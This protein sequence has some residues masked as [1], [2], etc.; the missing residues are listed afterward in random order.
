MKKLVA[1]LCAMMMFWGDV[2]SVI[3]PAI[4]TGVEE[5][6]G[7]LNPDLFPSKQE[8]DD[9]ISITSL[10]ET[11]S[12]T[13]AK[14]NGEGDGESMP[15]VNAGGLDEGSENST[16]S[17][18]PDEFGEN[19]AAPGGENDEITADDGIDEAVDELE[20]PSEAETESDTEWNGEQQ[21]KTE[22][23]EEPGSVF[24]EKPH[25]I[26]TEEDMTEGQD[27]LP[28]EETNASEQ[29]VEEEG[30]ETAEE[31]AE[32]I[33]AEGIYNPFDMASLFAMNDLQ[34]FALTEV[35][36]EVK[37]T[38][39][40]VDI[41][42][43]KISFSNAVGATLPSEGPYYY[44]LACAY[45]Q[46]AGSFGQVNVYAGKRITSFGSIT[47]ELTDF[48]AVNTGTTGDIYKVQV[49]VY[50]SDVIESNIWRENVIQSIFNGVDNRFRIAKQISGY[51]LKNNGYGTIS[52]KILNWKFTLSEPV[53]EPELGS[54]EIQKI[55]K[56]N[57]NETTSGIMDGTY[58]FNIRSAEVASEEEGIRVEITINNGNVT[59]VSGNAI[60][61]EAGARIDQLPIGNYTVTETT[62][63]LSSKYIENPDGYSHMATVQKDALA[64]VPFVSN[65]NEGSLEIG[66]VT[67]GK[68]DNENDAF[69]FTVE[70]RKKDKNPASGYTLYTSAGDAITFS[71]GAHDFIISPGRAVEIIHIPAGF[72]YTVTQKTIPEN[73]SLEQSEGATVSGTIFTG[74]VSAKFNYQ[75][76][77]P[78]TTTEA[79]AI[80]LWVGEGEGESRWRPEQIQY[81]LMA[82]TK[83]GQAVNLVAMGVQTIINAQQPNYAADWNNLPLYTDNGAEIE[84]QILRGDVPHYSSENGEQVSGVENTWRFTYRLQSFEVNITAYKQMRDASTPGSY[85][86]VLEGLNSPPMPT[87]KE[88]GDSASAQTRQNDSAGLINFGTIVY[89][90]GDVGSSTMDGKVTYRYQI[91]EKMPGSATAENGYTV[92][93]MVYDSTVYSIAVTVKKEN[94]NLLLIGPVITKGNE[95]VDRAVFVNARKGRGSLRI[96]TSV[97]VNV[98][99]LSAES[100]QADKGL[101]SGRYYYVISGAPLAGTAKS[102]EIQYIN[103]IASAAQLDGNA[104]TIENGSVTLTDLIE[105]EYSVT[106]QPLTN[107]TELKAGSS[108]QMV[109]VSANDQGGIQSADFQYNIN[110]AGLQLTKTVTGKMDNYT[111]FRFEIRLS[112]PEGVQLAD[113]Y[114]MVRNTGTESIALQFTNNVAEVSLKNGQSITIQGIPA[115]TGYII[116]ED[117]YSNLGYSQGAVKNL[118]GN[119]P[120]SGVIQANVNNVFSAKGTTTFKVKKS[121]IN[122][123]L[124]DQQFAFS[125]KQVAGEQSETQITSKLPATVYAYTERSTGN[126]QEIAFH[127]EGLIFTEE[128][129]GQTYWFLIEEDTST[130][131]LDEYNIDRAHH[132]LYGD[133]RKQW[134]Q[135]YVIDNDE[136]GISILKSVAEGA[137]DA[138][139]ASEQLGSLKIEK[140]ITADQEGISVGEHADGTYVFRVYEDDA[141]LTEAKG[142]DSLPIGKKRITIAQGE[143]ETIE[144]ADL[145]AGVYYVKEV[146]SGNRRIQENQKVYPVQ[147]TAGRSGDQVDEATGVA[148]VEGVYETVQLSATASWENEDEDT[149]RRPER[150][151]FTLSAK[152]APG[153]LIQLQE[154]GIDAQKNA[155][156]ENSYRVLW[157]GLP[158]YSAEGTEIIYTVSA[159]PVTNYT[160][161]NMAYDV[162]Q[163]TWVAT[164]KLGVAAVNLSGTI[165]MRDQQKMGSYR[166]VLSTKNALTP[167][168]DG[169]YGNSKETENTRTGE[170]DFGWITYT[171][172]D[173]AKFG[174]AEYEEE[175]IF[176][177]T[178]KQIF[179]GRDENNYISYDTRF[180]PAV[181]TVKVTVTYD[182]D[183]GTMEVSRV[184]YE[185]KIYPSISFSQAATKIEFENELLGSLKVINQVLING[186][187]KSSPMAAGTYTYGVFTDPECQ[188]PAVTVSGASL[189]RL[190]FNVSNAWEAET[191]LRY[192]RGGTYYVRELETTNP[193]VVMDSET[194]T[195]I[196]SPGKNDDQIEEEAIARLTNAYSWAELP[197]QGSIDMRDETQRGTYRYTMTAMD[198][199]PMPSPK[200]PQT[201]S[202]LGDKLTTQN[203][204]EGGI[205]FGTIT[206]VTADLFQTAEDRT[207]ARTYKYSFKQVIDDAAAANQN[208]L[209]E[210]KYDSTEYQL[211]VTLSYDEA[212]KKIKIAEQRLYKVKQGV[213]ENAEAIHFENEL[214]GS[215]KIQKQVQ[216][217]RDTLAVEKLADGVYVFKVYEDEG[218]TEAK[219]ANGEDIGAIEIR[220]TDGWADLHEV[221]GL[222]AGRYYVKEIESQNKQ[223]QVNPDGQWVTVV[224]GESGGQVNNEDGVA[225][226]VNT[227]ETTE[228]HVVINW[229][230]EDEDQSLRPGSITYTLTG[231]D[232][233]KQTVALNILGVQTTQI[234]D[235]TNQYEVSWE[236]LPVYTKDGKQ[237]TYDVKV[238][239]VD[240]YSQTGKEFDVDTNTWTITN[241]L[242]T[243]YAMIQAS[244]QMKH[245][246]AMGTY[247]FTLTGIDGAPMPEDSAENGTKQAQNDDSGNISF[248][249][250]KYTVSD[251][252]KDE[253]GNYLQQKIW[254]YIITENVHGDAQNHYVQNGIKYDPTEY[255]VT[256]TLNYDPEDGKLDVLEPEYSKKSSVSLVGNDAEASK[257]EDG[258]SE[259][260]DRGTA[261]GDWQGT[262]D[263]DAENG[264][265]QYVPV[266]NATFENER[267]GSLIIRKSVQTFSETMEVS[268]LA[269]GTYTF[270]VYKDAECTQEASRA[271]GSLI[272]EVSIYINGQTSKE[273]E[274]TG[275]S[276][277]TYYV[278]EVASSNPQIKVNGNA[279]SVRV[280]S[281]RMGSN[282][283]LTRS[284][285][286]ITNT[287]ETTERHVRLTWAGEEG[288]TS[289]R[290]ESVTYTLSAKDAAGEDVSL[291]A[292]GIV[293]EAS[294]SAENRYEADWNDLPK[295]APNGDEIV[296]DVIVSDIE[297]YT[298]TA[299]L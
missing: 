3:T 26:L 137:P 80:T 267:L 296:Y 234:A 232:I 240:H 115:G 145:H 9:D 252:G 150:V 219:K 272:D 156:K 138:V 204:A 276:E 79:H 244:K 246:V 280:V 288:D 147:V 284:V 52:N 28:S 195:V 67:T 98:L 144:I 248:G 107:G 265:T 20:Q 153:A 10:L 53:A 249:T 54:L 30:E 6:V 295:Y 22:D 198:G 56:I 136:G 55:V 12:I 124:A 141:C 31:P 121:F 226:I 251:L 278:K 275:L 262:L 187:E 33:P 112:P 93:D 214:L 19:S 207:S 119:I 168:P 281:G 213:L 193:H 16:Y 7:A 269:D 32:I 82:N 111:A 222:H 77:E 159:A 164:Y 294:G 35:E 61:T 273:T 254:T 176:E 196:V 14:E 46:E 88:E 97:T 50:E 178:V 95:A 133:V 8:K 258:S 185:K 13:E 41:S 260:N 92:G 173:L 290:P 72:E 287:F 210:T 18:G 154:E 212:Q 74:R 131:S 37:P 122:G 177:Y 51:P 271:D 293:A 282:I 200:A 172:R 23:E 73:Y 225:T 125:L 162:A 139:F 151:T 100:S 236:D 167:M 266:L 186:E 45:R 268:S 146:A 4:A 87:K 101:V 123:D 183:E 179:S 78:I 90:M 270:K 65:R 143:A 104:I 81:V 230:E 68:E 63:W 292:Y 5:T 189:G 39:D 220:V 57:G 216:T 42:Q 71:E 241:T 157:S 243:A 209:G 118:S 129:I 120:A 21:Q 215:L 36:D 235:S 182:P 47:L 34:L 217:D 43:V 247:S 64:T 201:I 109:N 283:D 238:S 259:D 221:D 298:Q 175:K 261:H 231:E 132:V 140:S 127:T 171:L 289:R 38:E 197:I 149:S 263:S 170:I 192:L 84:Y 155:E 286:E 94:G 194:K 256:V 48:A 227:Y 253:E 105:G 103:G 163:E 49:Y 58:G 299:D 69:Q 85:E 233:D 2:A 165:R 25:F 96:N 279:V 66:V 152:E 113:S 83:N 184:Q 59:S 114:P 160:M 174:T 188:K 128:D 228:R 199:G 148:R 106:A 17:D 229:E 223:I 291:S 108:T 166:F 102:L 239:T 255:L 135:V 161:T 206:F 257:T 208:I 44:I 242:G 75:Y 250:I 277:G 180:D 110:T 190:Q 29:V 60:K 40:F 1:L 285:V 158:K 70:L 218:R 224:G 169:K 76:S 62:P 297:N 203:D 86:F 24:D 134:I 264:S 99:P 202:V 117:K 142:A 211:H 191:K 126:Q 181:Y 89:G 116:S 91:R 205:D 237:I 27:T 15:M 245:N 11:P 274:V 130:I